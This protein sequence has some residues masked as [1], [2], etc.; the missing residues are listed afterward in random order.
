MD[1]PRPILGGKELHKKTVVSTMVVFA[2]LVFVSGLPAV[3][4]DTHHIVKGAQGP[5]DSAKS[6]TFVPNNN[7]FWS[8]HIVNS[9]LRSLVIDVYDVD[10][11]SSN[12]LMHERIRFASY[13]TDVIDTNR[14]E[15][16]E[17]R[18]YSVTMTPNGAQ[19][20]SCVVDD[21]FVIIWPIVTVFSVET[22]DLTVNVDASGSYDPDGTIVA[23]AWD[24]G[25]GYTASGVT[26]SHT[27]M[28]M[29]SYVI[30]LTT[31]DNDGLTNSTSLT[32][33]VARG[34]FATFVYV[35]DEWTVM[36]DASGSSADRGIA[37][38]DWSWGD[39]TTGDGPLATHTYIVMG[40]YS[41]TLTVTDTA[42]YTSTVSHDASIVPSTPPVLRF[43]TTVLAD[44][45]T[46]FVDASGCIGAEPIATYEWDFG[47]VI[48]YGVTHSHIY[49]AAGTF[50]ITLKMTDINGLTTTLSQSVTILTSMPPDSYW[51]TLYGMTYASDGV[52]L[53]EG[54]CELSV[55]D[56][57]TGETLIG[58]K[59]EGGSYYCDLTCLATYPGDMLVIKATGPSGETGTATGPV[60][61]SQGFMMRIDVTLS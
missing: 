53:L 19:G 20:S 27:Y 5:R 55:T 30:T 4:A 33:S 44:G 8:W 40:T 21:V 43:Y 50:T 26:A 14:V 52:S 37:S 42:G 56:L 22:N 3:T 11:G 61:Y 58:V 36:V 1:H 38:Y 7:G 28:V 31:L 34:P 32:V 6:W 12:L 29:G 51:L 59:S 17:G 35:V 46:V 54:S 13:S 10:G 23:Y 47:G 48:A 45:H 41:I 25:D 15:V 18:I 9:G 24:F 49:A 60:D 2:L 57:R 39:G 16:A